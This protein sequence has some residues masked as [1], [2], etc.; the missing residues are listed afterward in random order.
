MF[1]KYAVRQLGPFI[2]T[3]DGEGIDSAATKIDFK[4]DIDSAM[5]R[6]ALY[7]QRE[8]IPLIY[9]SDGFQSA[10]LE[11]VKNQRHLRI[12][13]ASKLIPLD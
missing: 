5:A 3:L 12:I 1:A 11:I 4:W 9:D 10:V 13:A 8:I 2:L 6:E 7:F